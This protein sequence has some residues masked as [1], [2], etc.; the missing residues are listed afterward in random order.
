MNDD[1]ATTQQQG[2]A[3][4]PSPRN[5]PAIDPKSRTS[6][7][8]PSQLALPERTRPKAA[9]LRSIRSIIIRTMTTPSVPAS[10]LNRIGRN[11]ARILTL[12]STPMVAS[13]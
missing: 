8:A 4:T 6:L 12:I 7:R 9:P 13:P 2:Q 1:P 10:S 5:D 3:Q 11:L